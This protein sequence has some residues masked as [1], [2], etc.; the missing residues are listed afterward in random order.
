MTKI[1]KEFEKKRDSE[2]YRDMTPQEQWEY[3]KRYGYLDA[4]EED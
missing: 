1:D 3:D 2:G 4:W